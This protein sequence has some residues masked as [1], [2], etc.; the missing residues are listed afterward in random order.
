MI[1]G[2]PIVHISFRDHA[3]ASGNNLAACE[4][5]LFGVLVKEDKEHYYVASW[6]CD[7]DVAS[8]DTDCYVVVKHKGIKIRRLK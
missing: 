3:A 6:V 1:K 7:K 4:I 8:S 2:C 5:D